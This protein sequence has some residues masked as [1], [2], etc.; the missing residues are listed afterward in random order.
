MLNAF[1]FFALTQHHPAKPIQFITGTK[2]RGEFS[3]VKVV[4]CHGKM[5]MYSPQS[6][7]IRNKLKIG[8]VPKG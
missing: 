6:R 8:E 1:F 2:S 3:Q 7:T 4:P 5:L